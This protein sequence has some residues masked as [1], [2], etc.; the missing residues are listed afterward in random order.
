[1]TDTEQGRGVVC[2]DFDDDGDVDIFM[3]NRGLENSGAFWM[4]DDKEND[5][6]LAVRAAGRQRAEH[7]GRRRAHPRDARRR[8]ADARGRGRQQ[9]H[10]AES[11]RRRCSGSAAR[12]RPIRSRSSGRTA[13]WTPTPTSRPAP[14]SSTNEPED[15]IG[16][17]GDRSSRAF[18]SPWPAAAAATSPDPSDQ[19]PD[20]R[21]PSV[22]RLWNDA[23][24]DAIRKDLA[25]PTVHA[26][27]LFHMSAAMYDAWARLFGYR[28]DRTSRARTVHGF[29]CP[30]DGYRHGRSICSLRARRRSAT[31]PTA[32]SAT[33]SRPR[34]ARRR[35][36]PELDA[37][38][39]DARL[40]R[41]GHVD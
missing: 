34:P 19:T 21:D 28:H 4:N 38:M 3:T 20:A 10:V 23:L 16:V 15:I 9:L 41:R 30:M 14:R 37:L 33:G 27:N 29:A 39:S 18:S 8:G 35:R 31:R 13:A 11:D 17:I 7:R 1:M 5:E 22:A 6:P 2:A 24:L 36:C 32:S 26:R 25:R 40:R 12:R